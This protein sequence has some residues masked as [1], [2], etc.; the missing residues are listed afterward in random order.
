MSSVAG[1]AIGI[2]DGAFFV[3]RKEIVDWINATLHLSINRIED[4]CSGAIACQLL[5]IMYPDV[6]KVPMQKINWAANKDFE[7]VANYKILQSAF[8]KAGVDKYI[9]VDRLISGRYMDNLEFMQWFK[10]FFETHVSHVPETYDVLGQRSKGKGGNLFFPA[11]AS[12]AQPV[13]KA[14]ASTASNK[15]AAIAREV[16]APSSKAGASSSVSRT[17]SAPSSQQ[18]VDSHQMNSAR[19]NSAKMETSPVKPAAA[20]SNLAN[21]RLAASKL[22]SSRSG[23]QTNSDVSSVQAQLDQS[24]SQNDALNRSLADVKV[25]M[26]GLEKERDFYFDKLREIEVMLQD[27]EENGQGNE[28]SAAIFKILYATADGFEVI[29]P[30]KQGQFQNAGKENHMPIGEGDFESF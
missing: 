17:G 13:N 28:I 12:K 30:D 3:G 11:G 25:E 24:R 7:Y 6:C 4:T 19:S 18:N 8:T 14:V 21:S 1:T 5:D 29:N 10:K 23:N 2:M 9:D 27:K 16:S 20:A 22:G 15:V 26:E